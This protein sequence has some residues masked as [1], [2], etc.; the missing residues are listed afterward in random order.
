MRRLALLTVLL[1]LAGCDRARTF[2]VPDGPVRIIVSDYRYDRQEVRV[3]AGLVTFS[4]FNDGPE[5]TNFRVRRRERPL[6]SITTFD[7][8]EKGV[9]HVRLRPGTYTMYSSVGRHETLGE[10]GKLIVT[11]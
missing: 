8:G 4:V 3:R 9:L 10:Y 1:G 11:P 6:G 5:P 7:P 2:A